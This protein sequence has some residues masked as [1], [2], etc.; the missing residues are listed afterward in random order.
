MAEEKKK[1]GRPPKKKTGI[2]VNENTPSIRMNQD[3]DVSIGDLQRRMRSIFGRMISNGVSYSKY[4]DAINREPLDFGMFL[5]NPFVQNQRIKRSNSPV[6]LQDKRAIQQA[7][8]N[9]GEN[10]DNLRSA[11]MALYYNN[12]VYQS[13]LKLNRDIPQYFYYTIPERITPET[14]KSEK[15]IKQKRFVDEFLNKFNIPLTFK[16]VSLQASR[17]G[18]ASYVFRSSQDASKGVVD[19]A[20]LQKLPPEYVKYTGFGSESPLIVSYN[21]MCFL[22]PMYSVE[23]WPSWFGEIWN[24]LQENGIVNINK[25]GKNGY[26]INPAKKL[27][28]GW[29]DYM[30]ESING[31]YYLYV[32]MP[33]D[34]VYTFG[35]DFGDAFAIPDYAGLFA[36]LSELEAYKIL[37]SQTL[38]TN[39]TNILT[40]EVPVEK[41]AVGGSDAAIL[42]P[43]VIMGLEDDCSSSLSSNILPF[44]APLE[45]FKMH[46]VDHIPNA[47]DIYLNSVRNVMSTA[48]ASGLLNTN[49]K[50]SIAMIKGEQMLHESRT[51]YMTLQYTKFINLIINK[52]LK[53]DYDFKVVIWGGVYTWRDEVKVLKEMI[54]AGNIGMLP[55][56]L[57]AYRMTLE[58]YALQY[59]YV[60][61]FNLFEFN[62]QLIGKTG[63][64]STQSPDGKVGRPAMPIETIEN[65]STAASIEGGDNVSEVK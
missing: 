37:Q 13:L 45:N 46:G 39:I 63:A 7:L 36:D 34:L 2:E 17:E 9:P 53:L 48:G 59:D 50:P 47:T 12:Y 35:S 65:D 11:S 4:R 54:Q 49:E 25:N 1:R 31:T 44:F 33:Q 38:L 29:P 64:G 28:K 55:R 58:D 32:E 3:Q 40:A 51:E 26:E 27:G 30:F 19:F 60:K 14:L 52:Y 18:K 56:L 42:S 23:Q 10:E 24:Q 22:N 6:N 21:F 8:T 43:E 5:N 61:N 41:D 15:F 16:N 57:S 20:L 62:T